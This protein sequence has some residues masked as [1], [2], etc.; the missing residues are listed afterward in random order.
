MEDRS[1]KSE[2]TK[3]RVRELSAAVD[4]L[5]KTIK[6]DEDL[7][8]GYR[9]NIAMAFVDECV[10]SAGFENVPYDSLHKAANNAAERFLDNWCS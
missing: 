2:L 10:G 1:D 5:T 8:M 7:R 6:E 9:S 4:L 3:M